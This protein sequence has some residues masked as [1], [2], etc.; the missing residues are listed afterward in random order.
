VKVQSKNFPELSHFRRQAYPLST[1]SSCRVAM[2]EVIS[3]YSM[4]LKGTLRAIQAAER[5]RQR[6][7]QKRLRELERQAKEHAKLSAIEQ[8]RLEVETYEN[9]VE[10]LRSVH[11]EQGEA[12]DWPAVAASLP[13]PRPQKNS[14][15]EQRANQRFA[16]LQPEKKEAAQYML[17]QAR[18]QDEQDFQAAMQS[19]TEQMA[20]WEKLKSMARRILAGEHKAYTESLVEFNPFVDI[21]D[22]GSSINFTVHSARLVE[23]VLKVSGKQIIPAEVKALTASEKV[24]VKP[25]TKGLFHGIYLDYLCGCVLRVAREVFALLPV[26]T[27]LVTAVADSQDS[28]TSQMVAL[29]RLIC[30]RY[31]LADSLDSC[32]VQTVEQPVLS[33]AMPRAVVARLE[34][35][36]IVPSTAMEHFQH[37]AEF[38]ASR[39]TEA[40]QPI[41]PLTP[42]DIAETFDQELSFQ[43]LLASV[44][45]MRE[46]LKS[47]IAE[48]NPSLSAPTPET[49][50]TL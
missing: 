34:F 20:E 21:S 45:K 31:H 26:D 9:R 22:L 40:F 24:S 32:T 42:E 3:A 11:K 13:P 27:V 50:P 6:E 14:Q 19:Y 37:R 4:G 41:T 5:R 38:K 1:L 2:I 44:E 15:H 46:E 10:L 23:C 30:K 48:L 35:D 33:V 29:I 17:E 43:N 8:A 7:A 28:R 39:K 12:W 36:Q 25:M 16:V 18:L 47:K 49:N